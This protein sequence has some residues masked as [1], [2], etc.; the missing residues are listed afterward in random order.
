[1]HGSEP[2]RYGRLRMVLALQALCAAVGTVA[3]VWPPVIPMPIGSGS[4]LDMWRAAWMLPARWPLLAACLALAAASAVCTA[5]AGGERSPHGGATGLRRWT[6]ILAPAA[7]LPPAAAALLAADLLP[8]PCVAAAV[9]LLPCLAAAHSIHRWY[10]GLPP[11]APGGPDPWRRDLAVLVSVSAIA[12]TLLGVYTA[13]RVGDVVG[14]D[15]SAYLTLARSLYEDHDL[16]LRNNWEG[17]R[18]DGR[19]MAHPR[20]FMHISAYSRGDHWYTWHPFGFPLL[21][22]PF[23]PFGRWGRYGAMALIAAAANAGAY[24]CCR[25]AGAGRRVTNLCV[26][27][28]GS[29]VVWS[30]YASRAFPEMLGAALM[31]WLLWAVLSVERRLWT[32]CAAAAAAAAGLCLTQPRFMPLA[33]LGGAVFCGAA[34]A[35]G[36]RRPLKDLGAAP[37]PTAPGWP[38]RLALVA[39]FGA[40][41]AGTLIALFITLHRMFSTDPVADWPPLL[42][43]TYGALLSMTVPYGLPFKPPAGWIKPAGMWAA[44]ADTLGL[45]PVLPAFVLMAAA[46]GRGLWTRGIRGV[47]LF[48]AVLFAVCLRVS[49]ATTFSVGA[50]AVPGRYLVVVLPLLIPPL[51]W[52]LERANRRARFAFLLLSAFSAALAVL[53]ATHLDRTQ[54]HLGEPLQT[55]ARV[56]PLLRHLPHPF[57]D[58]LGTGTPTAAIALSAAFVASAAAFAG[59]LL[60]PRPALARLHGPG[61]AAV[62][63]LALAAAAAQPVRLGQD[64]YEGRLAAQCLHGLQ[65]SPRGL[66]LRG[67]DGGGTGF[68]ELTSG[69]VNGVTT[70]DLGVLQSKDLV[71]SLPR[72]E[73]NDWAG[74]GWRWATLVTPFQPVAGR[75]I[76]ALGGQLDGDA[77]LTVAVR[78]GSATL[79]EREVP[80][81]EGLVRD[82]VAVTARGRRGDLYILVRLEGDGAATL[83]LDHLSWTPSN[84][85]RMP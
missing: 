76:V 83:R 42:R 50:G 78:E 26:A 54:G 6:H 7:W 13:A 4:F 19:R 31:V 51:A 85:R 64:S 5:R 35:G 22:A 33:G 60:S 20:P 59:L 12:Y 70:R 9:F 58:V 15:E 37:P 84:E 73:E 32:A 14:G 56:V 72:V 41:T 79:I 48:A 65:P 53:T 63:A 21:L 47:A 49:C 11:A 1:M 17:E 52:Q 29:S 16:D 80:V 34:L 82:Q 81:R 74:R 66:R 23:H 25:R 40:A 57:T 69:R 30:F 43:H 10:E 36:I 18:N 28:L 44:L 8:S 61:L 55:L 2:K 38:H 24:A 75:L 27:A 46:C 71:V 67:A 45:I 68:F 77:R 3:L 39:A 62:I